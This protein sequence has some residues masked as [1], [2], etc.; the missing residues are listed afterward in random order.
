MSK[1]KSIFAKE[2]KD[3]RGK[4]TIEVE[5]ETEK[6]VYIASVPSGASTGE[7][8][9]LELR[10]SDGKGVSTA[11]KNINEIIGYCTWETN[12]LP[13]KWVEHINLVPE[14]WV[15]SLFNKNCFINSHCFFR[16]TRLPFLSA[17]LKKSI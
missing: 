5:L 13:T 7:N 10:D 16:S 11:V 17:S 6:G 15:P 9:A 4:P 1:I 14:V 8:E 3:S 12:K 2:I